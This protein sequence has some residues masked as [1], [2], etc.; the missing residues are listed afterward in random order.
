[1]TQKRVDVLAR[2]ASVLP[3]G[4][5]CEASRKGRGVRSTLSMQMLVRTSEFPH[6]S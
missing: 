5:R 3:A 2:D 6:K 4:P 1:M